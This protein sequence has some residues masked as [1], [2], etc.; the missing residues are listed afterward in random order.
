M[1]P[2]VSE[3]YTWYFYHGV[4]LG[5]DFPLPIILFWINC[6]L[7]KY[8]TF[9]PFPSS[10]S[11]DVDVL[12]CLAII[13]IIISSITELLST[14]LIDYHTPLPPNHLYQPYWLTPHYWDISPTHSSLYKLCIWTTGFLLDS[15]PLRMG[16]TGCPEMSVR[17]Y[18]YLLRN[19]PE[20]HSSQH[21]M[22]Q[23]VQIGLYVRFTVSLYSSGRWT[24]LFWSFLWLWL[25]IMV[26]I[27]TF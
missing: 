24:I 19:N 6:L 4:V 14:K 20:E 3:L 16:P 7:I 17:N 23:H 21:I 27:L 5:S 12:L 26:V 1:G 8:C 22:V 15:W 9:F 11:A 13:P 18:H 10:H 2:G 25:K